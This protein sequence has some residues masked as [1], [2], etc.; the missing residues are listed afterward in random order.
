MT[1]TDEQ[2]RLELRQARKDKRQFKEQTIKAIIEFVM[3]QR[4][5]QGDLM[6]QM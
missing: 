6:L 4:T 3:K 2:K 1:Y 5:T